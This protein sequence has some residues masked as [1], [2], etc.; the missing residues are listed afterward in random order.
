MQVR[1]AIVLSSLFLMPF[2][3]NAALAD[4]PPPTQITLAESKVYTA[5]STAEQHFADSIVLQN[6]ED[7]LHLKL[8]YTNGSATTPSFKW[9]RI[10][11]PSMN[12][13]TEAQFEGKKDLTI[14]VTGELSNDGNQILIT[15]AG[16]V[17]ATFS[18]KLTTVQ[19]SITS[20]N[21]ATVNTGGH[22]VIS[23]HNFCSDTANDSVVVNGQTLAVSEATPHNLVVKIPAQ[24]KSGAVDAKIKVAGLDAGTAKFTIAAV[25]FLK[26]VSTAWVAAAAPFDISGEN[27]GTDK[28]AVQV[29]VGPYQA[30]VTEVTPNTITAVSPLIYIEKPMGFYQPVKVIVKGVKA[31]NQLTISTS[32]NL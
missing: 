24:F 6:G 4:D 23:G 15:G 9:L 22:V 19:P 5:S 21:P 18:W 25:P 11:S 29:W 17:G 12:Y 2:L 20:V 1:H 3:A 13:V 28:N 26:N 16:P 8:T 10:S 27:F 14:D 7:K 32:G 30:K 31:A